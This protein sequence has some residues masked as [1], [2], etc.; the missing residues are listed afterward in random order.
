MI[1]V[2]LIVVLFL[3]VLFA[4]SGTKSSP[5]SGQSGQ[6]SSQ[7][8]P[9]ARTTSRTGSPVRQNSP[10]TVNSSRTVT[11]Q[12]FT[13]KLHSLADSQDVKV[14]SSDTQKHL[15]KEARSYT[16]RKRRTYN[17]SKEAINVDLSWS[18]NLAE[19]LEATEVVYTNAQMNCDRRL[20][21]ERF[22]YYI[23]LHYRS[24]TAA[25]LCYAK[26]EE[27]LPYYAQ[28]KKIIERLKDRNDS[29]RVD[30]ESFNQLIQLRNTMGSICS[31]LK[32]RV[33][34]LNRQTKVLK[35]KIRDECGQRGR[36]W[37]DRLEERI[38]QNS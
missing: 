17:T 29:L 21:S 16:S 33:T 5:P 1:I 38:R 35:D 4:G 37:Y 27:I 10:R 3:I 25:D 14:Q 31:L 6:S 20:T 18:E 9:Q 8:S 32:E 15:V 12:N 7:Y 30:K 11:R 2:I 19:L 13:Q 24:F 28:V 23:N 34:T 22:D 26:R 36:A